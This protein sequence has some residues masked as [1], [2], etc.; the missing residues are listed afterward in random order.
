MFKKMILIS[1]ILLSSSMALAA[2][3]VTNTFIAGDAI[4]AADVNQN[5]TDVSTAIDALEARIA[6]LEALEARI[7]A[8]EAP[9]SLTVEDVTG[10]YSL[11]IYEVGLGDI[12]IGDGAGMSASRLRAEKQTV[13]LNSDLTCTIVDNLDTDYTVISNGNKETNANLNNNGG[14]CTYTITNN[15]LTTTIGTEGGITLNMMQGGRM[16]MALYHGTLL[17]VLS[18]NNFEI[19]NGHNNALVF[20]IKH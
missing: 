16:G 4:V 8:L 5:F 19:N 18:V 17:D 1:S 14:S 9:G 10:T 11:F 20:F 15:V 12:G 2:T 13:T 6:P 3:T 7:A